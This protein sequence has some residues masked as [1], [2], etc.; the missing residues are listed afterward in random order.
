[1]QRQDM[2]RQRLE[3]QRQDTQL[4][5][6]KPQL[7]WRTFLPL[8]SLV[9]LAFILFA[10]ITAAVLLVTQFTSSPESGT[11]SGHGL[12][13]MILGAVLTLAIG[14]A[15]MG[16]VFFSSRRGYDDNVGRDDR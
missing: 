10:V 9:I 3:G 5:T 12:T 2:Q 15:L 4:Q 1:M 8:R 6:E 11:L 13:A 7:G 14:V 16:L